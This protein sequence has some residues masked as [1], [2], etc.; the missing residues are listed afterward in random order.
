[1][2]KFWFALLFVLCAAV[3][4][5]ADDVADVKAVIVK[6]CE[7]AAKRN[8]AASLALRTRDYRC[9]DSYGITFNYEQTKWMFLALDGQHPVE[10]W[11]YLYSVRHKG[12]MPP[13]DQLSRMNQLARTPKYVKLYEKTWP[14]VAAFAQKE[15][16]SEL[17]TIKFIDVKIS[18]NDALAV[19]EYASEDD[20][21]AL[22]TK[23][24]KVYLRKNKG[25]WK[26]Y[27]AVGINKQ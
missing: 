10:F 11:L 7:L 17:K 19:F 25:A 26:M 23:I 16:A 6:D 21:G 1:M 27:R 15:P 18:G 5:F 12:A 3:S 2:K 13:E 8:F 24:E 14:E 4:L 9:T 22:K 20:S